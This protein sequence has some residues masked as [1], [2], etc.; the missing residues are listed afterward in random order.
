MK[1]LQRAALGQGVL[2]K[3]G[4]DWQRGSV[5]EVQEGG[6]HLLM[7]DEGHKEEIGWSEVFELPAALSAIP[8]LTAACRLYTE[9][10][11]E[12]GGKAMQVLYNIIL[13]FTI[14][15]LLQDWIRLVDTRS[16]CISGL[17]DPGRNLVQLSLWDSGPGTCMISLQ[18]IMM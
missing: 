14:S 8:A 2:L 18:G 15:F 11:R 10:G 3:R 16:L 17:V 5:L 9:E 7:V 12:W 6:L 1:P 4:V 13:V